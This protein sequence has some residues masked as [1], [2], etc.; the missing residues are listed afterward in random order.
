MFI[1]YAKKLE[2]RTTIYLN[3]GALNNHQ[4][5]TLFVTSSFLVITGTWLS[6]LFFLL[7]STAAADHR[8]TA[9]ILFVVAK[10]K[11]WGDLDFSVIQQWEKYLFQFRGA[12]ERRVPSMW[13]L[14]LQGSFLFCNLLCPPQPI[15]KTN[16][17][18]LD[19][20]QLTV[21]PIIYFFPKQIES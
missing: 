15:T 3:L 21:T 9:L 10:K 16:H 2:L 13:R 8:T 5:N 18:W 7:H 12:A 20:R 1:R 11:G 17:L 6:N 14:N 4:Y 19:C